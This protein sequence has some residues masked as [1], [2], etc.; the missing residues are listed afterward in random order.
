MTIVLVVLQTGAERGA[1]ARGRGAGAEHT[2][3][4]R[5]LAAVCVCGVADRS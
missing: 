2:L 5:V 1:G 3:P 4:Q